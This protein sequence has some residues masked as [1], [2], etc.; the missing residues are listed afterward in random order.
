MMTVR[1]TPAPCI[2]SSRVSAVASRSGLWAPGAYGYRGSDF[3]TWTC[4]STVN[5]GGS[6]ATAIAEPSVAAPNCLRVILPRIAQNL[7]KPSS[8]DQFLAWL[9]GHR[10]DL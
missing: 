1:S 6:A 9:Q 3:H 2:S 8:N 7:P 5:D 10:D 4:A